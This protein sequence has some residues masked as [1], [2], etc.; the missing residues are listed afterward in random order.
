MGDL[1]WLD[2]KR[3]KDICNIEYFVET[4]TFEGDTTQYVFENIKLKHYYTI[5]LDPNY[6]NIAN[7]RFANKPI[8]VTH[9]NS[10]DGLRDNIHYC[11]GNTLFWLDAHFIN[12]DGGKQSYDSDSNIKSRLPLECEL[13]HILTRVSKFNDIII[14]DD[15]RIYEDGPYEGGTFDAHMQLLNSTVKRSQICEHNSIEPLVSAFKY[16]H[17]IYKTF[18]HQGYLILL[19]KTFFSKMFDINSLWKL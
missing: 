5:E 7:K 1:Y 15:V 9:N 18:K 19:P 6:V 10:V 16:T 11:E 17:N 4:G 13:N 14:I 12:S 2:L 8:T 3:I